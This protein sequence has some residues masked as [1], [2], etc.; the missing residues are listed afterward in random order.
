MQPGAPLTVQTSPWWNKAFSLEVF[1]RSWRPLALGLVVVVLYAPVLVRMVSQFYGDPGDSHGF[2]IPFFSAYLIWLKRD[3]LTCIEKSPSLIGLGIVLGAIG[4]LYLGSIGAE[5][6]L[7]RISLVFAIAGLIFYF[8]GTA[9]VRLLA[10]PLC[11]LLLM[12][13]LPA[14]IYNGLVFPLQLLSSRFATATLEMIK[15]VPVLR[16][17]NLLILPHCTLEVVEACSGIRSLMALVALGLGYAYLAERNLGIRALLVIAMVPIAIVA[18]GFRV[19]LAAL[20]AY[21]KGAQTVDGFLHPITGLVIFLVAVLSL[22][23]LHGTITLIRRRL[24]PREGS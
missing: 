4:L 24:R 8:W 15:V 18:N 19:V 22:L 11:F 17:G 3:R 21:Y 1:Q 14:I 12:I 9:T 5:L 16:E 2:L 20:L 7:T 23:T 6:F 13:P 10:F